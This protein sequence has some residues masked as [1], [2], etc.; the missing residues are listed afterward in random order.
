MAAFFGDKKKAYDD[1]RVLQ[2]LEGCRQQAVR[3]VTVIGWVAVPTNFYD[4]SFFELEGH[5][6][7]EF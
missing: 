4:L 7:A 6:S 3:F 1:A 5:S 2:L